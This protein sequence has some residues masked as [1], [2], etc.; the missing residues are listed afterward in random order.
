MWGCN[1]SH[2]II[3]SCWH[4]FSTQVLIQFC[5]C[6][7]CGDCWQCWGTALRG[8]R[9]KKSHVEQLIDN[10]NTYAMTRGLSCRPNLLE[11]FV[12]T[13]DHTWSYIKQFHNLATTL[14]W[15]KKLIKSQ[16]YN[17]NSNW[18]YI[19]SAWPTKKQTI[20]KSILRYNQNM[21][22]REE[23]AWSLCAFTQTAF[24]SYITDIYIFF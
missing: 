8:E 12:S 16:R 11:I 1:K 15:E 7:A 22:P 3:F 5:R 13:L 4:F 21:Q 24:S 10:I 9:K 17:G 18:T 2:L 14:T 6:C 23:A 20:W 19:R